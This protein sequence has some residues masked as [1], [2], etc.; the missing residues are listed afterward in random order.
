MRWCVAEVGQRKSQELVHTPDMAPSKNWRTFVSCA[1]VS[2]IICERVNESLM[3]YREK[4]VR[5]TLQYGLRH[6]L[7]TQ[8][9]GCVREYAQDSESC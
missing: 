9:S 2:I 6:I 7:R 8:C 4:T 1:G 5:C 3:K